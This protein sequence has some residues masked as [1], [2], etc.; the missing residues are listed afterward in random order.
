MHDLKA[1]S[2][3]LRAASEGFGVDVSKLKEPW[4]KKVND[5]FNEASLIP[6]SG[7]W[8][9][10]MQKGGKEGEHSDHLGN[11]LTELQYMQRT[12]PG[13]EW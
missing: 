4:Q 5:I 6:P 11:I 12:Y 2:Y 8:G 7:G 1:V 3:E 9:A 10:L 13:C